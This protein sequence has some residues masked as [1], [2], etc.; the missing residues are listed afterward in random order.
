MGVRRAIEIV[1]AEANKRGQPPLFTYGPLIHNRQVLEVL[2]SKGVKTIDS[3]EG[4]RNGRVVI[5]AHGI[6]P[7]TR[8]QLRST[9][10]TIID[11]TCP[12]VAKVQAIIRYYSKK[13]YTP[14]IVG[15]KEHAEV[16]GL[17]GYG[18]PSTHVISTVEEVNDIPESDQVF[19]VAQTT[20]NVE[21]YE[22][23]VQAI[24][25]RFRDPL[26]F[27][28]ICEATHQRQE[29][30][31]SLANQADAVVVVGGYHS[32]NTQRLVQI[33]KSTGTPT[34]HIETEKQLDNDALN[35]METVVV[36]AG[37]STPNW[38]IKNVVRKIE[39]IRGKR[40]TFVRHNLRRGLK[41]L[42]LSN[43]AVAAGASSF[44][45]AANLLMG[46][47]PSL[48]YGAITFF[49]IYAM[50]VLNRFLDKGASAYNEPELAAFLKKHRFLLIL[51]GLT[52]STCAI[53]LSLKAGWLT[54]AAL[55]LLS[56]LGIIYSIPVVPEKLQK[57]YKYSKIKDIPGSK[58]LS[59]ALAWVAVIVITPCLEGPCGTWINIAITAI[60]VFLLSYARTALFDI[61]Q[62]QGDLIV[63]TETLPI[64]IGQKKTL[65]LIKRMLAGAAALLLLSPITNILPFFSYVLLLPLLSFYACV[66]AYQRRWVVPSMLFE[67]IVESNFLVSGIL[68]LFWYYGV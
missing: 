10:L 56:C 68:A 2:E 30:I 20:Q 5:R 34:F 16:I 49:Y 9:G 45:F 24:K 59:E 40:D 23:I 17:R 39:A 65:F 32:G 28:T 25:E 67:A 53:I 41:F 7:Q 44:S 46:R 48:A 26:I 43:L 27:N 61:F 37:A 50:H 29:E 6:P 22:S 3:I 18:G 33:A 52:S 55:L 51:L 13:G 1:L 42:V 8:Q 62:F 35:S 14:I 38:M 19:V 15:D 4:I 21:V 60:V 36:T 64:A 31:R 66:I 54:F 12:K 57:R 58:T 47:P 63:G 11:A